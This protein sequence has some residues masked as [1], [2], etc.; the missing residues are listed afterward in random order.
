MGQSSGLARTL[1]EPLDRFMT[2]LRAE[3][4]ASPFTRKN[5]GSEI[6]EFAGFAQRDGI[7]DWA[8]VDVPA[9]RRYLSH[10]AERGLARASVSRRLS[11]LRAFANFLVREGLVARSVYHLVSL[12]RVPE[13]LPKY[14]EPE[15]T[16]RLLLVP[17]P[18]SP[19]GLRDRAILEAFYA[20]GVRVSELVGLDVGDYDPERLELRVLGK[21]ARERIAY[22]GVA[23]RDAIN[24]YL[25]SGRPPL[26]AK[27][28]RSSTA[29]FLNRLGGRLSGRSVDTLVRGYAR[30][31]GIDRVVTPHVLRHTFA[32]HLLNGGADLRYVQEMLGHADVSTTQVYTHVSQARLRRVYALAHPRASAGAGKTPQGAGNGE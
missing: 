24:T 10:L 7:T 14:L 22:L 32:T 29:L 28:G 25:Q 1:Q 8:S 18:D 4:D 9:V 21:G 30:A 27:Q 12:P 11:E 23:A 2:Y 15:E 20:A 6:A 5:Y 13:R 16:I 17:E 19:Q 31:A 3:R 26:V